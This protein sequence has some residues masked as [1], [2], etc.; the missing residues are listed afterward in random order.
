MTD[1]LIFD[2]TVWIEFLGNKSTPGANLLTAYIQNENQVFLLPTIIQ[3]VLQGIREDSQYKKVKDSF[4]YFTVLQM[5]PVQASVGA[6]DLYRMLRK[7]GVTIRKSN[8]CLIAYY[9]IEFEIPLVHVDSDFD[10]IGG[11]SDLKIF[12]PS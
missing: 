11:H 9:A 2:T 4:S 8:D 12:S 7:K 3:E 1:P 10:L 6:A 5:P